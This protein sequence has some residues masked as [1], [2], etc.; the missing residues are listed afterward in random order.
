MAFTALNRKL[1]RDLLAMRGQAIAIALVVAAGVSLYI[2]YLSNFE[3]LQHTQQAYYERQRFA[4]VFASLK[5]APL[6][7]AGDIAA[8]P[9]VAV[10]EPRVV[11][12]V[13][14]DIEG[15]DQ[16][17]MARL[18]SVPS[19]RRPYLNDLYLRQGRWIDPDRRDE[20]MASE[21]FVNAHHLQPGDRVT[22]IINGRQRRLIIAG[23]A[24]SPEFIYIVNP[25][26]LVPDDR[27]YAVFWIDQRS[28]SA[29]FDMDG[30]FNDVVV[31]IERG[32]NV[33]DVVQRI[34]TLLARFGGTG[35]IP[36]SLQYSDWTLQNE[37]KQLESV[38]LLLPMIFL[39]VAAFVLN[40]ALARA[41]TLQRAQIAALKALG[42]SNAELAWHYGKW[43][44]LVGLAGLV[45]GVAAGAWLGS[46]IGDVYNR[47]FRFPNLVFAVPLWT[48]V[49]ATGFTLLAASAGAFAA[50]RSAVRIAPA[51]AMRPE[52]PGK[53]RFAIIESPFVSGQLGVVGRMVARN[54]ARR[55][56]R[57]FAS[58]VGIAAAVALLMVG[59]V[60]FDA[61]DR[62]IATQFWI[63]ERQ[64][65]SIAFVEPRPASVR[66]ELAHLPGV[67]VVE[68]SRS[69]AAFVSAPRGS[70]RVAIFGID[71]DA[72]L[73][74]IVDGAGR[75]VPL[76][77]AGVALSR[78]LGEVLHVTAGDQ[79]TIMPLEGRR[80]EQSVTVGALADD[81]MG[82]SVYMERDALHRLM[83]E[84]GTVSSAVLLF[85]PAKEHE[86]LAAVRNRPGVAGITL[87]RTV[88]RSFRDTM[89]ATMNVTILVNLIF[90]AI[91]AIGVVYNAARVSL[92]ERSH[93][94]ASLR[95]LGYTRGEIS[96]ILLSELAV[97]T[98]AA[99][100]L[101]W[102]FGHALATALFETV[103]SEVYRFPMYVSPRATAQA[104][105]GILAAAVVA[106]LAVRRRLDHLDLIAVLKVRE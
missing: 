5:R 46:L 105:T 55:P 4:D 104:S 40:V 103:Q 11:A 49:N 95:V 7:V 13:T 53:Y 1:L 68:P 44:L 3:S 67:T 54:L 8:I 76:P 39:L 97:L 37:L 87:K 94:L 12:Q 27:R 21:G 9:G 47:Y 52:P 84:G 58:I 22:A 91:I 28:L 99:L 79:V 82:L 69:V 2:T 70:R 78:T 98:V 66:H 35:A 75:V 59:M 23:V 43:A 81:V 56:L 57:A 42:Y 85:D 65:A 41:L 34:D 63:A 102:L 88:L 14:L 61:M 6:A 51:E 32:A 20:I 71:R 86:L 100:P 96:V 15:M 60:M 25:G 29:T 16:P 45:I 74:R 19:H 62:L 93:E 83:R 80:I 64:D 50:V 72:Q 18:V 106:A 10:V 36:R 77:A 101:G 90:A 92:S 30:S 33:N 89:A 31:G 38:G 24:L 26:E 17:A 48:I 73:Q